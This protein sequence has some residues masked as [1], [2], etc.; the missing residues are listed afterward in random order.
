MY[1]TP[2]IRSAKGRKKQNKDSEVYNLGLILTMTLLGIFFGQNDL[3]GYDSKLLNRPEF[4]SPPP[5]PIVRVV[6]QRKVIEGNFLAPQFSPDGKKIILTG[7]NYKGLWITNVNGSGLQ[8]ITGER[9]AGWRPV[10]SGFGE[11]I[12]RSSDVDKKGNIIYNIKRYDINTKKITEIYTG[13]NEDIY[14]AKLSKDGDYV[15]FVKNGKF[16]SEKLRTIKGASPLHQREEKVVFSDRGKVWS[17][18]IGETEPREIS[19]GRE[20]T[21]GEAL[22]PD[23]TKVAYLWGNANSII[24]YDSRTGEEINIGEGANLAWSP[25]SKMLAYM[26]SSDDGHRTTHSE[27]FIINADGTG[28]QRLTF[29][30]NIV[31][32]AP[33]WSPDGKHIIYEDALTGNIHILEVEY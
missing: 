32:R 10:A 31:E 11:I 24:I 7:E 20:T 30:K 22:S 13:I 26:V 25:N 6:S 12:F 27:I 2:L 3:F 23:G 15:M 28:K 5:N 4:R 16:A 17:L 33:S 14:P 1:R 21:G 8:K 18:S 19:K 9:M 29:T